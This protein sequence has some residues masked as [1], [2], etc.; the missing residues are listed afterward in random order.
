MNTS[1]EACVAYLYLRTGPDHIAITSSS[2]LGGDGKFC[3]HLRAV[4][5]LHPQPCS[6]SSHPF[7]MAPPVRRCGKALR[8]LVS[9]AGGKR[10]RGQRF[11]PRAAWAAV[12]APTSAPRLSTVALCTTDR[13][14]AG[15]AGLRRQEVRQRGGI[16]NM[17][18][19]S[20]ESVDTISRSDTYT[21]SSATMP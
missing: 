16:A 4:R 14:W 17:T 6:F 2:A 5:S 1:S 19:Q 11:G 9:R 20:H 21:S 3:Y 10:P 7:A 12:C 18:N 15:D 8:C 13:G